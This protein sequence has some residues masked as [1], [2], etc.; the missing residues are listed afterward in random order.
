MVLLARFSDEGFVA[1]ILC[2]SFCGED[3]VAKVLWLR[4]CGEDLVAN[5]LWRRLSGESFVLKVLWLRFSGE[6]FVVNFVV[7][8]LLKNESLFYSQTRKTTIACEYL[9]RAITCPK[10]TNLPRPKVIFSVKN[11]NQNNRA[12]SI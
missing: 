8:F 5:V 7:N 2:R 9:T 4:F 3:F 1:K 6:G 11:N 12:Y 10:Q